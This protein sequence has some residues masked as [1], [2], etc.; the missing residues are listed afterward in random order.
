MSPGRPPS[1]TPRYRRA[2][3]AFLAAGRQYAEAVAA[4]QD[5]NHSLSCVDAYDEAHDVLRQALDELICLAS[6]AHNVGPL[7]SRRDR[8]EAP[9]PDS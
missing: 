8:P 2:D 4:M 6:R 3:R 1:P 5:P 7:V 9:S